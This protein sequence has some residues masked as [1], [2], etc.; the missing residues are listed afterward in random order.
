MKEIF[1][2]KQQNYSLRNQS[3][4]Y[5]NPSTVLDGLETFG[6]RGSQIWYNLPREIQECADITNY[7]SKNCIDI[8]RCNLCETYTANLGYIETIN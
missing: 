1:C 4:V 7:I 2:S 8:C 6:Y 5:P 3:L